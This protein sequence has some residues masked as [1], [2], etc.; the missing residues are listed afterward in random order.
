MLPYT[1]RVHLRHTVKTPVD[2]LSGAFETFNDPAR[3]G[4][5]A[6]AALLY[7]RGDVREGK[8]AV[9]VV[10]P[11][12][13]VATANS[14]TP[15]SASAY[16]GLAEQQRFL[17]ALGTPPAGGGSSVPFDAAARGVGP[18]RATD[19]GEIRRD[20]KQRVLVIDTDRTEALQ[21]FLADAG[22]VSTRDLA[23]QASTVFCAIVVS[24]LS[25]APIRSSERLLLTAVGR[26]ENSGFAY[27]VTRSKRLA[28]GTGPILIDP[29]QAII[30]LRHERRDLAVVPITAAGERLPPLSSSYADG[31]LTFTIGPASKTLFYALETAA[32][33]PIPKP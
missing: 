30:G 13:R 1:D 25:D 16:R 29:V 21:G 23:A 3:F 4:L 12:D 27:S 6:N 22:K 18:Q 19:T 20:L 15:G 5:F 11:T 14:P 24:S 28:A 7:R 32:S 2:S 8:E 10:I 31:W 33:A 9:A 17:T 26:A